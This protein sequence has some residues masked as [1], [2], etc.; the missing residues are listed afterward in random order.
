MKGNT[1]G[2]I[3]QETP[4]L[5]FRP[6]RDSD[7]DALFKYASDPEVGPRAGWPPHK[8]VEESLSV[9]RDIFSNGH[10]WALELKETGEP[11]GHL[12]V[13]GKAVQ[14]VSAGEGPEDIRIQDG[15][16]VGRDGPAV[17]HHRSVE[18]AVRV[19][20]VLHPE[21]KDAFDEIFFDAAGEF[22]DLTPRLGKGQ[23]RDQQEV[24]CNKEDSSHLIGFVFVKDTKS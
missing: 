13:G 19:Y 9:I 23:G 12:L 6:W 3:F 11:V 7:A 16:F 15:A 10:T 24:D 17:V 4:R 8:S 1:T 22:F 20:G 14:A 5:R 2:D 18:S 21:R